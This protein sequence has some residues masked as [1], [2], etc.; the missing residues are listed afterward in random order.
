MDVDG[1]WEGKRYGGVGGCW[2]ESLIPVGARVLYNGF[3]RKMEMCPSSPL[4]P[5]LH[6]IL[7]MNGG[8]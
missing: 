1:G 3:H 4:P 2:Q 5:G 8:E 7:E 6:R